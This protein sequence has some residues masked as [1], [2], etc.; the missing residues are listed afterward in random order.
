MTLTKNAISLQLTK[1]EM[2]TILAEAMQDET[3]GV[4]IKRILN[5]FLSDSF[6]QFPEHTNV[7]LGATDESGATIVYLKTPVK[8]TT[9]NNEPDAVETVVEDEDTTTEDVAEDTDFE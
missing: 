7:T 5:P 3:A 2:N 8:R 6:H 4:A 9:A 1:S